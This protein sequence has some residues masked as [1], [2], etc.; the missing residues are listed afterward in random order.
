MAPGIPST[1]GRGRW[2]VMRERH[3]DDGM[4]A[5]IC[6]SLQPSVTGPEHL[7][8]KDAS[9]DDDRRPDPGRQQKIQIIN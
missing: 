4:R 9:S 5:I 7:K 1:V 2:F 8:R 6:M 3:Q